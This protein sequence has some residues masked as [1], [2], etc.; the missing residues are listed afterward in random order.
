MTRKVVKKK[1]R[2]SLIY[3]I[4]AI[5]AIVAIIAIVKITNNNNNQVGEANNTVQNEINEVLNHAVAL[6]DGTKLNT[7]E[8]L[9]LVKKYKELEISNIQLTS[10]NGSSV[11]LA[12]V[13]NTGKEEHQSE[14][15]KITILGDNNEVITEI[16]PV[17]GN[18]KPGETI[19]LNA[20]VTADVVDAKDIKIEEKK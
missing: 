12:D 9:K 3:A 6:E 19:K 10:K 14:I 11:L 20:I 5:V 15:V 7:S 16:V 1:G 13:K 17:I 18:V 8:D 2:A 4:I